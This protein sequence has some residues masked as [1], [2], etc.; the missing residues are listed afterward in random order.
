MDARLAVL[1]AMTRKAAVLCSLF[2]LGCAVAAAMDPTVTG[3]FFKSASACAV[4]LVGIGLL[5][6]EE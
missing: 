5:L 1:L 6:L 3:S 4:G 2:A